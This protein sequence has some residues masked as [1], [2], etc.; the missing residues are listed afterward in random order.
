[1]HLHVHHCPPLL[2]ILH[3]L[4]CIPTVFFLLLKT[5]FPPSIQP[6]LRLSRIRRQLTSAI[7][8]LFSNLMLINSVHAS[9][10]FK[11]SL[12]H[13]TLPFYSF[14]S[15]NL[16]IYTQ[17]YTYMSLLLNFSNTSSE[18]H[19]FYTPCLCPIRRR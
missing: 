6:N 14:T 9:K 15:M 10:P 3:S 18:P 4:S 12:I 8:S 13:S 11:C 2:P 17:F 16:F 1:M 19:S 7:N 5:T